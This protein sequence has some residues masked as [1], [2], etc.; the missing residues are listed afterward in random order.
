MSDEREVR[1]RSAISTVEDPEVPVTLVDLGVV[2]EV[3]VEPAKVRVVLR[4]TR[5]GCPARGEMALRIRHAV[6][7]ADPDVEVQVDWELSAWNGEDV[8]AAGREVL[9]EFGYADPG[10]MDKRCPYCG[11]AEVRA[12]GAFGGAVCKVP[13][14]CRG[15]GS[16]FDAL[17]SGPL[18]PTEL[19]SGGSPCRM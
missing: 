1:I 7:G 8:S 18:P 6:L 15:C 17:R 16:T 19:G 13:Y 9:V 5:L 10:A 12:E 14:T 2:R 11:S 3:T 4:P